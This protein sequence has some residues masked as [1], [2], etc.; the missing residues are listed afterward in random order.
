MRG[1]NYFFWGEKEKGGEERGCM[2]AFNYLFRLT[3]IIIFI[4]SLVDDL[5]ISCV[6]VCVYVCM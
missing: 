3:G 2:Y 4:F 1:S 6:C 5:G